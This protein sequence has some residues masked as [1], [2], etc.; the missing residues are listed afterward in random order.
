MNIICEFCIDP[1]SAEPICPF[2]IIVSPRSFAGASHP[3]HSLLRLAII[4]TNIIMIM[5]S[6]SSSSS[7]ST[8][9][10]SNSIISSIVTDIVIVITGGDHYCYHHCYC[11]HRRYLRDNN[12]YT[13]T[14]K[15]LQG[16]LKIMYIVL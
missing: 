2:A 15:C 1:I 8:S 16:P 5:I 9:S 10:S 7:S 6:S 12:L 11:E 3:S 14:N 4:T 13:T